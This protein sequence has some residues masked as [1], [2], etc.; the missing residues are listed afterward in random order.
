MS[1]HLPPYPTHESDETES[2]H[3]LR[4]LC[5]LAIWAVLKCDL[6]RQ[7]GPKDPSALGEM[8]NNMRSVT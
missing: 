1:L 7:H 6:Y 8:E 4:F 5:L 3:K 2:S